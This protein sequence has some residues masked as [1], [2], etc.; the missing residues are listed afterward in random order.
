[1]VKFNE[2]LAELFDCPTATPHTPN[3]AKEWQRANRSWW[4]RRPMRYDWR[5]PN[6]HQEYSAAFYKDIDKRFFA[7][8]STYLS[9]N[10]LPFDALIPFKELQGQRVL[11]VG[12]GNGS[13]AALLARHAGSF[14]GIDITE[15]ATTSTRRRFDVFGLFGSVLQMDAECLAFADASFDFVWSWG[16]I[17]HSSDTQRAL[18][19]IA[20]VLRPGGRATVMVYHRSWWNY[21]IAGLLVRGILQGGMIRTRSLHR[22]IQENIDG[23]LARF[24]SVREWERMA[25]AL[26]TVE[27]TTIYGS[28]MEILP[29]PQSRL[30][31]VLFEK[32]PDSVS[33]LLLH[34]LRGGTFLVS[35]LMKAQNPSGRK[36]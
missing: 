8:A 26:L 7:D 6:Q 35:S 34:R 13:H 11:E 28:K 10:E 32:V 21:Y 15:Y 25:G 33:R 16:V 36:V 22:I 4:E 19:E 17:H 9:T 1:M 30:K 24:Y 18:S 20:R 31:D 5:A 3:E 23:A 29:L 12:V 2:H 14:T 27:S